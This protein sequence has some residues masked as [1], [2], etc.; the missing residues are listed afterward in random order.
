[1]DI[2]RVKANLGRNVIYNGVEYMLSG[3]IIRINEHGFYYQAEVQDLT[4]YHSIVIC[5]LEDLTEI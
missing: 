4:A 2:S 5:K 1:M 3:C